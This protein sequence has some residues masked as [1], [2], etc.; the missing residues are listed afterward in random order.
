[1]KLK[2]VRGALLTIREIQV[3]STFLRRN[4]SSGV[5]VS[6]TYRDGTTDVSTCRT[7]MSLYFSAVHVNQRVGTDK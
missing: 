3:G 4:H 2:L 6:R 7:R 1:M 5:P